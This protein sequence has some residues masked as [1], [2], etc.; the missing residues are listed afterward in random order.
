MKLSD[1]RYVGFY[2]GPSYSNGADHPAIADTVEGFTSIREAKER[3]QERQ[4]TSGSWRLDVRDV[5]L[6]HG[7]LTEFTDEK[8][9]CPG[10]S[11]EDRLELYPVFKV[12]GEYR[13]SYEPSHRITA[14]PRGG[15]IT[16]RYS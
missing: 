6:E 5:N 4:E 1:I 9:Y 3:F 12:D 7:V 14:G 13:A 10:T 16:E 11:P 8:Y 15:A 2:S